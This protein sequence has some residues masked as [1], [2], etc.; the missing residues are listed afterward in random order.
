MV[1]KAFHRAC[2]S[3]TDCT[4]SLLCGEQKRQN[5]AYVK[6][7]TIFLV[8]VLIAYPLNRSKT[9][10]R[11]VRRPMGATPISRPRKDAM[12]CSDSPQALEIQ[13]LVGMRSLAIPPAASIPV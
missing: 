13:A 1:M 3:K 9:R 2:G 7:T 11:S 8:V 12:L 5:L 6:T 4:L 10:T